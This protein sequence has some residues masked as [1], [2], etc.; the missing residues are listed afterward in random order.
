MKYAMGRGL[1]SEEVKNL[2]KQHGLNEIPEKNNSLFLKFLRKFISPISFMLLAA[3]LL[4]LY[5][6]KVFDF[7]FIFFLLLLNVVI[8][9]WQENK[10][11]DAI[12][13]LNQNLS[14]KVKTLRDGSW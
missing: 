9:L 2:L 10:A 7:Y 3:A 4:S 11:D 5:V 1:S 12:K 6:G 8:A 13:K 14:Q